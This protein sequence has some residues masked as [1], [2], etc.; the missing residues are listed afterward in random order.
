MWP[1]TCGWPRPPAWRCCANWR[2]PARRARVIVC[3]GSGDELHAALDEAGRLG[4]DCAGVLPKPF[5][6]AL[7][8]CWGVVG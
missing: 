4:L 6:L 7:K 1:S 2:G 8:H 3:S 5:T